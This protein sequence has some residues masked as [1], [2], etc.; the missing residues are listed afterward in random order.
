[1]LYL[2][3]ALAS[4][5]AHLLVDRHGS[6][7]R[8]ARFLWLLALLILAALVPALYLSWFAV[9]IL[10]FIALYAMQ[11]IWRPVLISRFDAHSDKAVGA[12]VLSIES[13]AKSVSTMVIAPGLGYV[14]DLVKDRGIGYLPFWPAAVFG[15]AIALVF[16]LTA[17]VPVRGGEKERDAQGSAGANTDLQRYSGGAS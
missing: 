17:E 12:T 9:I 8:T 15:A 1:V 13:Q 7:D 6:E 4:R 10:G 16:F 14:V 5:K 11:N 2:L 3:S